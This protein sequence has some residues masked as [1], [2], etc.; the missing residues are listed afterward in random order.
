MYAFVIILIM[1]VL[2]LMANANLYLVLHL[3]MN[4]YV[5]ILKDVIGVNKTKFAEKCVFKI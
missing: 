3:I 4:N 2:L 1:L 5:Q